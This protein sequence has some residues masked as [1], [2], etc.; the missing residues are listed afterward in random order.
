VR[1]LMP[2]SQAREL[3]QRIGDWL[4]SR[5]LVGT[6]EAGNFPLVSFNVVSRCFA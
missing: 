4:L 6:D 3:L 5:R 1:C 2:R